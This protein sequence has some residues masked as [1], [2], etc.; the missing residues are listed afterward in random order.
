MYSPSSLLRRRLLLRPQR[1][2]IHCVSR[3]V[4]LL[5]I[6]FSFIGG[7]SGVKRTAT[8]SDF[9]CK[10]IEPCSTYSNPFA[11]ILP[12]YYSSPTV[13]AY[14]TVYSHFSC[15]PSVCWHCPQIYAY[16]SRIE[17]F[18]LYGRKM[19]TWRFKQYFGVGLSKVA[20]IL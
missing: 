12:H 15:C 4:H 2:Q 8:I 5:V 1:Q 14:S 7:D 18:C 11:L 19:Y 6:M 16:S 20:V 10:T 13:A 9:P 3:S 17:S